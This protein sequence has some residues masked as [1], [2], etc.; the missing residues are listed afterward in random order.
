MPLAAA[1]TFLGATLQSATGFGFA[2]ILGP[3]LFAVLEPTE[4]LTT[5][6]VLGA[7]LNLLMLF[8]ERRPL[9]IRR[10]ELLVLLAAAAPGL[11]TGALILRALSKPALQVAVG[12]AVVLAALF[13]AR[14]RPAAKAELPPRM[15]SWLASGVGLMAGMLTTTTS[16]NGPPLVLWL[17]RLG[18]G[19]PELRDS[20]TAAFLPLNLLGALTLMLLGGEPQAFEPGTLALLLVFTAAGHAAGRR[21]FERL[22]PQR[23]R[24]IGLVLV[25][26]AGIASIVAGAAA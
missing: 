14:E 9:Q 25:I 7:S 12:I 2:L 16:T 19:P 10:R 22:D 17:Q 23:F 11:V 5:L 6:L 26:V 15:P 3:V 1:A 4:A 24:A 13:Q 20:I 8:G 18:L 21:M